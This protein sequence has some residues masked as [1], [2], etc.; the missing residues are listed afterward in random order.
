MALCCTRRSISSVH[1]AVVVASRRLGLLLPDR[2]VGRMQVDS[3]KD[4]DARGSRAGAAQT[5]NECSV[6]M[7]G[8]AA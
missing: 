2:Y 1:M 7:R 5:T 3:V 4:G 6:E 8:S